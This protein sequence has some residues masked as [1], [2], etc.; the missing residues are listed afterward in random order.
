MD[1]GNE[2]TSRQTNAPKK[3]S[4]GRKI[5]IGVVSVLVLLVVAIGIAFYQYFQSALKPLNPNSNEVV[6]VDIP[7]GASNKKI[8]SILQDDKIVKSGMVF[9]YY[10]KSHNFSD[11][12]AGYYQLKPSMTLN[13]I[14]KELQKGGSSEPIQSQRGKV[15]IQEGATVENVADT[16]SSQTDF[17]RSE[18]I[19]LMKN[20]SYMKQL[21]AK[22][23]KL[24]KSTMAGKDVRYRLEGYLY[25]AT[26]TVSKN[27]SLK[28]LVDS[29]VAQTNVELAPY[30]KTISKKH[31]TIQQV[32]TLSSLVEREGVSTKDRR[33]IAGVF[34]NRIA[35][36]MPLQSDI[37]VLY[38]INKHKKN[39]SMKDLQSNSPYNLYKNAGYGPGPFNN[40]SLD[41]IKA[42]LNPSERSE[43]YLYFVANTKTGKIY[44]SKTLDEHNQKA[45]NLQSVNGD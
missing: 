17:S 39:L 12:R 38:A 9:N 34:L 33:K 44:Y 15:L 23:P 21:A 25:P 2:P 19:N 14:A 31:M 30:F 3:P 5:I 32:L 28:R 35:A 13:Q 43:G 37:S 7:M 10:V 8:G 26:Y 18:F 29:M 20:Q 40:P 45:G 4:T 41:S 36:N 22:Y 1:N 42:V 27:M 6:Q 11:F 16:I 24:L